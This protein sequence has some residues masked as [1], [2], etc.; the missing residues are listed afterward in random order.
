[1]HWLRRLVFRGAWLDQR[2]KEGEL[3][4]SFDEHSGSFAYVQP[5][6]P[7]S[8]ERRRAD[9]AR[10]RALLGPGRLPPLGAR[11]LSGRL[12]RLGA[13]LGD[14]LGAVLA[15]EQLRPA[16]CRCRAGRGSAGDRPRR[17]PRRARSPSSRRRAGAAA[18]AITVS[19][20]PSRRLRA[21]ASALR[22]ACGLQRRRGCRSA[23][24]HAR[25]ARRRA[26]RRRARARP[27]GPASPP[28]RRS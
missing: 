11:V 5:A 6:D 14:R 23:R 12:D 3:G 24:A 7:R 4:V 21:A 10:A 1:M 2:V 8:R 16:A 28:R 26:W 18:V 9:R 17:A 22:A 20:P 27:P 15:D 13:R 25:R 19:E